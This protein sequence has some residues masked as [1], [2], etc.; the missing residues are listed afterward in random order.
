MPTLTWDSA[1]WTHID[2]AEPGLPR[3]IATLQATTAACDATIGLGHATPAIDPFTGWATTSGVLAGLLLA[4]DTPAPAAPA[5][6]AT[7]PTAE[8]ATD[9]VDR[10]YR[11]AADQLLALSLELRTQLATPTTPG[12]TPS[13]TP[14][15]KA[16]ATTMADLSTSYTETFARPW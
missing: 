14:V 8:A 7:P 11:T 16:L 10:L 5:P 12:T 3:L 2:T 9:V 4:T 13:P 6:L 1:A 15:L